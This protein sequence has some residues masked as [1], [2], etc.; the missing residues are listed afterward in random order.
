M[1]QIILD[2]K[3]NSAQISLSSYFYPKHLLQQAA[4]QFSKIAKISIS[5]ENARIIINVRP[6]GK[7][8]AEEAALHFC[9]F[10]LG[11]KRE[12]GENA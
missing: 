7:A 6:F 10:A 4:L 9:N 8:S 1:T 3:K 12:L 11:L 2:R 5:D